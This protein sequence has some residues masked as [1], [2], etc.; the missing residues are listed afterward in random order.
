MLPFVRL[1][2]QEG[3]LRIEG[4]GDAL[5]LT[6]RDPRARCFLAEPSSY[7]ALLDAASRLHLPID[8]EVAPLLLAP[9]MPPAPS[10]DPRVLDLLASL[11]SYGGSGVIELPPGRPRAALVAAWARASPGRALLLC[12]EGSVPRWEAALRQEDALA[13]D[14]GPG[15]L[16]AT[17]RQAR[18]RLDELGPRVGLLLL[19]DPTEMP[20]AA[21]RRLLRGFVAPS[22][23]GLVGPGLGRRF[24]APRGRWV[25]GW[26]RLKEGHR[27]A[28]LLRL[29][30]SMDEEEQQE[31]RA[32]ASPFLE[33][34]TALAQR[35]L[36][37][38]MPRRKRAWMLELIARHR[39]RRLLVLSALPPALPAPTLA[40]LLVDRPARE[41]GPFVAQARTGALRFERWE[42]SEHE[43]D[44]VL[45]TGGPSDEQLGSLLRRLPRGGL[46]Y[47]LRT[48]QTEEDP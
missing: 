33:Q 27:R 21:L 15:V 41:H 23:V 7:A 38:A 6:L 9:P 42:Q 18:G 46:L 8:D 44:V 48:S 26:S 22:V 36:L 10:P 1:W 14:E 28:D 12:A 45:C 13:S 35:L 5:G 2:Y 29:F 43:A 47:D 39:G 37:A 20:V 32:L 31:H 40:A 17:A 25:G 34:G 30:C 24:A 3:F 16:L 4:A 11:Q 19:D